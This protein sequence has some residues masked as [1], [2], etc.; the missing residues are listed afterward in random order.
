MASRSPEQRAASARRAVATMRKP[1]GALHK[2]PQAKAP[3]A[4][5]KAKAPAKLPVGTAP[6]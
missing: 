5:A 3:A 4:K 1:G 6:A 2:A